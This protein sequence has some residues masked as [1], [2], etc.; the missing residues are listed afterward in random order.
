MHAGEIKLRGLR[1]AARV[2]CTMLGIEYRW[3]VHQRRLFTQGL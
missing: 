2:A 3:Y 1:L